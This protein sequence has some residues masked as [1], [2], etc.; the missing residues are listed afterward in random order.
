MPELNSTTCSFDHV[1]V[2]WH[3]SMVLTFFSPEDR[4]LGS[5]VFLDRALFKNHMELL[6]RKG[7]GRM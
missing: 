1:L 2:F 4:K 3:S 5:H 6:S 7:L